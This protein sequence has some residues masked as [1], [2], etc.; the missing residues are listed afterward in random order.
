MRCRRTRSHQTS[1]ASLRPASRARSDISA[2]MR[3]SSVIRTPSA[4]ASSCPSASRTLGAQ[5]DQAAAV[6]DDPRFDAQRLIER[7]RLA[8]ANVEARGRPPL[9]GV[10]HGPAHR[11]ID[12][13][14]RH[15]A[16]HAAGVAL[17]ILAR[18]VIAD[19][20]I[21]FARNFMCRPRSFSAAAGE[22]QAR[23]RFCRRSCARHAG[24]SFDQHFAALRRALH[25]VF[26]TPS[27]SLGRAP[28]TR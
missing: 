25:R 22:A 27:R 5:L 19:G 17:L 24:A 2:A 10:V 4:S 8:K 20:A 11:L 18:R 26:S 14:S 21:A 13:A 15:A 7:H 6:V 12:A 1:G 3:P 23:R 9:R 28:P 16:V